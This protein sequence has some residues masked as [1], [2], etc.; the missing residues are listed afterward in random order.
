MIL[1]RDAEGRN[2]TTQMKDLRIREGLKLSQRNDLVL[3]LEMF[4]KMVIGILMIDTKSTVLYVND[5]YTEITG[6]KYSEIV[7]RKLRDV[8]PKAILGEIVKSGVAQTNIL[9]YEGDIKYFVDVAPITIEGEIIGGIT[10]MKDFEDARA[11]SDGLKNAEEQLNAMK[12]ALND[13]FKAT[14]TFDDIIGESI[15]IKN[16]IYL[17]K[18]FAQSDASVLITGKTGTGKE[19]FAQSIHNYSPRSDRQFIPINCA[20]IP[21]TLIESELFGYVPGAFTGADKKGKIGLFELAHNGTLFMDEIE[22]MSLDLQNKL[23][24]VLQERKVKRI[25]STEYRDIDVRIIAATNVT[26]ETIIQEGKFRE[27]LYYRMCVFPIVIPPLKARSGDV[28]LLVDYFLKTYNSRYHKRIAISDETYDAL[29]Q[30]AWPGNVRELNNLMEFLLYVN[31]SGIIAPSDLPG[32][33]KKQLD[34]TPEII[35]LSLKEQL[36]QSEKMILKEYLEKYGNHVDDK[37]KIAESLGISIST[38]YNKLREAE[39]I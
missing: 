23:L 26:M 16:A 14:Y 36:K 12:N 9:R 30:Y 5:K 34:R 32:K 25:G 6:V 22:N 11:I 19:L 3:Y 18:K 33:I 7:G 29:S 24:R 1:I 20:N 10:L 17:A 39:L 2:M 37:M 4:E 28:R 31:E 15:E 13:K 38:L 8:R 21:A 35:G 27:D